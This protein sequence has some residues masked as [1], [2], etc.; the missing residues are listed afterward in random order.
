MTNYVQSVLSKSINGSPV[1]TLREYLHYVLSLRNSEEVR[2]HSEELF[3]YVF[4]ENTQKRLT[5]SSRCQLNEVQKLLDE[6]FVIEDREKAAT[7]FSLH[8][9]RYERET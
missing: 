4:V 8:R 1:A 5:T 2:H 6:G 3:Q 9:F 7:D